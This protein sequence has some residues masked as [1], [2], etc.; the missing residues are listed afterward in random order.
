MKT[1]TF[2]QTSITF[3]IE[4]KPYQLTLLSQRHQS[5]FIDFSFIKGIVS[6]QTI[7]TYMIYWTKTLLKGQSKTDLSLNFGFWSKLLVVVF[8]EKWLLKSK[9]VS[10]TWLPIQNLSVQSN[11][12]SKTSYWSKLSSFWI[13]VI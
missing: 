3:L 7:S 13:P 8:G 1:F 2:W 12:R 11:Y 10:E 5:A 9:R 6:A 4:T